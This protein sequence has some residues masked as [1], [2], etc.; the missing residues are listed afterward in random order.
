M[1]KCRICEFC[2]LTPI[3]RVL[4]CLMSPA[5]RESIQLQ[6]RFSSFYIES[7]AQKHFKMSKRK[8]DSNVES[9][10]KAKKINAWERFGF[11]SV[12]NG[13]YSEIFV[14]KILKVKK[15]SSISWNFCNRNG[16]NRKVNTF[17]SQIN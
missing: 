2:T 12:S 10:D 4:E 1:K 9:T 15:C 11:I 7:C 17:F 13:K 5:D 3:G 14:V 8:Q 6:L 16:L